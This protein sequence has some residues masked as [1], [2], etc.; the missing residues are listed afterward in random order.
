MRACRLAFVALAASALALAPVPVT[1]ADHS[2][3]AAQEALVVYQPSGRDPLT[4]S[5]PTITAFVS[6]PPVLVPNQNLYLDIDGPAP[7]KKTILAKAGC[8]EIVLPPLTKNGEYQVRITTEPP[9]TEAGG[10]CQGGVAGTRKFVVAVPDKAPAASPASPTAAA[11][12]P[13][14]PGG[15]G[16]GRAAG[17]GGGSIAGIDVAR[18]EAEFDKLKAKAA[19]A[20]AA[21]EGFQNELRYTEAG[22]RDEELGTDEER[23]VAGRATLP[24]VAGALLALVT[25]FFLRCLRAEVNRQPLPG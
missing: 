16:R 11:G 25:F 3:P 20:P 12:A 14:G 7:A 4:T 22:E 21:D 19:P 9:V 15:A 23:G 5:N 2:P 10:N 17:A 1:L 6:L 8:Q 13:K 18:F 24:F